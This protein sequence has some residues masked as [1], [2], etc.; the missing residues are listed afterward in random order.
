MDAIIS[1]PGYASKPGA[2]ASLR[3][4]TNLAPAIRRR[5][6]TKLPPS[7]DVP[8]LIRP[9]LG[10]L[11]CEVLQQV[12]GF[13]ESTVRQVLERISRPL[14]YTTVMTT[15]TRLYRKG[16]LSC[17]LSGKTFFYSSRLSAAQLEMQLAH[18][19]VKALVACDAVQSQELA[20]A[21]VEAVRL[22]RPQLL[23]ELKRALGE[24]DGVDGS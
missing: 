22:E 9:V 17:R 10:P 20:A 4:R 11:E 14:A 5:K 15:M 23:Q 24:A 21:I 13:G 7:A 12:C 8:S 2:N 1:W 19:L 16:L 3:R 6:N 18:D